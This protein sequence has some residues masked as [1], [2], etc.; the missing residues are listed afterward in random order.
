MYNTNPGCLYP[1][2]PENQLS[3]ARVIVK[4]ARLGVIA[5]ESETMIGND[6]EAKYRLDLNLITRAG[7]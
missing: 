6:K 3:Q 4:V 7:L 1:P 2:T 5:S